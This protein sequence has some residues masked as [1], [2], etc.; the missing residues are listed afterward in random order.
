MERKRLADYRIGE[1]QDP[2]LPVSLVVAASSAFPPFL[3]PVKLRFDDAAWTRTCGAYLHEFPEFRR[4]LVVTDGG[5]YDNMATE[6]IW[7]RCKTV[8]VSD[9]GAPLGATPSP[10]P[11][12]I[13]QVMRVLDIATE[14]TRALRRRQLLRDFQAH[15]ADPHGAGRGGTY[16]GIKTRIDSYHLAD[17]LAHDSAVSAELQHVP[18]R[19]GGF[20]TEEQGRLVNWGYA[21]ADAGVRRF[22]FKN[23]PRAAGQP[24]PEFAL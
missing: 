15:T 24:I 2:D 6:V 5:V 23:A 3:S 12:W 1:I 19:L 21:L 8:L 7:D 17:A 10:S 22:V 16:W 14:Q 13:P 9:A 18:T 11:L 20:S 4:E